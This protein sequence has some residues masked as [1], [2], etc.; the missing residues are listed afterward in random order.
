MMCIYLFVS[1]GVSL[2]VCIMMV[3]VTMVVVITRQPCSEKF[4]ANEVL[5]LHVANKIYI[6]KGVHCLS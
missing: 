4:L 3:V 5:L 6:T 2:H 1:V